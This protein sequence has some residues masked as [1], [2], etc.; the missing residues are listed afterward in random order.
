MTTEVD[1]NYFR[2]NWV[3]SSLNCKETL[4]TSLSREARNRLD[5]ERYEKLRARIQRLH[6]SFDAW[7]EDRVETHADMH[8]VQALTEINGVMEANAGRR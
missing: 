7:C 2:K 4:T 6:E 1:A 5:D 3:E 8:A